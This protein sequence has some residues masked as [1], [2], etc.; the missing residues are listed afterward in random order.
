VSTEGM[1]DVEV[2][3][4][5]AVVVSDGDVHDVIEYPPQFEVCW[6]PNGL[7]WKSYRDS[8]R[9]KSTEVPHMVG[10]QMFELTWEVK[11]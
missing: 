9:V 11:K 6:C 7:H 1:K 3:I 8:D 10:S 4:V 5:G 2:P